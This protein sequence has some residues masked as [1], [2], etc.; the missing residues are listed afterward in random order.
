LK[1][2]MLSLSLLKEN[3]SFKVKKQWKTYSVCSGIW[4]R[5]WDL[6]DILTYEQAR[7]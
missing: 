2:A 1:T 7:K 3:C 5:A 6:K 4:L